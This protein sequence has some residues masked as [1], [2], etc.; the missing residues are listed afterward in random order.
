MPYAQQHY[1]FENQEKVGK[2]CVVLCFHAALV[3]KWVPFVDCWGL[4]F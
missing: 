3:R 4:M 2:R 1:P